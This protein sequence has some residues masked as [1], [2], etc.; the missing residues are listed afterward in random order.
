MARTGDGDRGS[1]EKGRP[2]RLAAPRGRSTD[3]DPK[4]K[5]TVWV[6]ARWVSKPFRSFHNQ[7]L[8]LDLHPHGRRRGAVLSGS[9]RA[10]DDTVGY[11]L[12]SLQMT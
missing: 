10:A 8:C 5:E 4:R 12:L 7:L 2:H 11:R 6:C 1:R 9:I 3:P